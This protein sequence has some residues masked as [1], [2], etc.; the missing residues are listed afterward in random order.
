LL[1]LLQSQSVPFAF[2]THDPVLEDLK[3]Y[4]IIREYVLKHYV[5]LDGTGGLVLVDTR[6]QPTGRFGRLGFPCFG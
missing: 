1:A 2:S 5:D 6:R 4:P 3:R